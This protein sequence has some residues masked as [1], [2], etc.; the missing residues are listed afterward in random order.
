MEIR[1][2]S[3][4]RSFPAP[5][6]FGLSLHRRLAVREVDLRV[7]D[8]GV[9]ALAGENGSGKTTTLRLLAGLLAPDAGEALLGGA[10]AT[11]PEARRGLGYVA[12]GD[13]FPPGLPIR[14]ILRYAATLAGH[15]RSDAEREA[16]RAAETVGVEEWL[17]ETAV[18][19]SRGIRRRVS[20]AQALLGRPSA[21]ILDEPL[22]GLDPVARVR[23]VAAIR[24]A[25]ASGAAVIVSLHDAAAIEALADRLIVLRGGVVVAEG[26]VREFTG[27]ANW[28]AVTLA[29]PDPGRP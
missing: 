22:T 1:A 18:R 6:R 26:P 25:A 5:S 17:G 12:E 27:A 3:L 11:R 28:L 7:A 23:S 14:R 21:L 16:R 2:H 15:S 19:C 20:L 4:T 9:T 10:P 24:E 29:R 13:N 8:G